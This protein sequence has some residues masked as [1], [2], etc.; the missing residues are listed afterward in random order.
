MPSRPGVIA[1][2]DPRASTVG[3]AVMRNGG[4]AVDA[5]VAAALVLY[6]VEPHA[7]GPGGD[8]FL[9]CVAPGQ[10]PVALDGS[11][12]LPQGLSSAALAADGLTEVPGRGARSATTPGAMALLEDALARFGTRRLGDLIG[13]AIELAGDGFQVRPTLAAASARATAELVTDPVL[14][15]LYAPGGRALV[16][17]EWIRN[18]ALAECLRIIASRGARAL[19]DDAL[20]AAIA[21]RVAAGGGYLRR[22]DMR[23]HRTIEKAPLSAGFRHAMVWELPT[24]TQGPAVLEA[25]RVLDAHE[26]MPAWSTVIDAV[27]SG[28]AHAGFDLTAMGA[29]PAPARGDTTYIAAI[30]GE[31][32]GASLITSVF[33]DFGSYFGIPELGGPIGNRAA[34]LRALHRAPEP[35]AKPPH[36]T[37]PAAVT[38]NGQLAYVFGVAGG[39]MQAQAQVQ[40]LV[41]LLERGLDPQAAI[42]EPRFKILLGGEVALEAGHPLAASLPDAANR[43]P[44]LEGF[45]AAQVVGWHHGVLQGGA[46]ARRG[47]AVETA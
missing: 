30:D 9:I 4:N 38:R 35:G 6:V 8:A 24:P 11:G 34:M 39:F 7:C 33:G 23:A 44:G 10:E 1:T 46:D 13:P 18:P 29:R 28:M 40:I 5:A 3:A 15:P 14:G 42:D 17:R 22:D 21:A 37:I 36:T 12:A 20:G 41:H 26:G 32:L 43:S 27:G 25:L 45:G 19:Y 47:G 31:G 16:E 2:S